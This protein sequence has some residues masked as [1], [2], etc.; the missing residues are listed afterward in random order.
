MTQHRLKKQGTATAQILPANY[1]S[2]VIMQ[3]RRGL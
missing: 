2:P 3:I 1:F